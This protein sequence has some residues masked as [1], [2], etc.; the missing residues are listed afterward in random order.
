MRDRQLG[1]ALLLCASFAGAV[2][3]GSASPRPAR[4]AGADSVRTPT[5]KPRVPDDSLRGRSGK[6]RA[7][8]VPRSER[9]VGVLEQLFGDSLLR[10]PGVHAVRDSGAANGLA[11]ITMRDFAEKLGGK[12]GEYRM[13]F[14]PGE[15]RKALATG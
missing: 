14:W 10:T 15:R 6:L 13:G 3:L 1:R 9:R 12:I 4:A 7:V 2:L 8:L 11:L 5:A